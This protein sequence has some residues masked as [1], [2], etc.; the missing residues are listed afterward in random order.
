MQQ[1][2]RPR[3]RQTHTHQERLVSSRKRS[4]VLGLLLVSTALTPVLSSARVQS[5][6]QSHRG[7]TAAAVTVLER[8][9]LPERLRNLGERAR[10]RGLGGLL[11]GGLQ[12]RGGVIGG[13]RSTAMATRS[14]D[15][16]GGSSTRQPLNPK[17]ASNGGVNSFIAGG[18][19]GS[20]STTI[21]CPIEVRASQF[22]RIP[23][24]YSTGFL[25]CVFLSHRTSD[26]DECDLACSPAQGMNQTFNLPQ[27]KSEIQ[28]PHP[29]GIFPTKL[30]RSHNY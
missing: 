11:L 10:E 19:A 13:E 2:R 24:A 25:G 18:L 12:Q 3:S 8:V 16:G 9:S 26:F 7:R 5:N 23:S 20:I 14:S 27:A 1:A 30:C 15:A 29:R 6:H 21:T 22:F 17:R 4:V 28:P